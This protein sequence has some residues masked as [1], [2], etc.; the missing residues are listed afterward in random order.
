[1][2]HYWRLDSKTSRLLSYKII[3]KRQISY[4]TQCW[5]L[6]LRARMLSYKILKKASNGYK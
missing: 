1:V 6:P 3:F 4:A 2:T 5:R